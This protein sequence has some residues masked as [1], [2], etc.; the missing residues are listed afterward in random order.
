MSAAT[1]CFHLTIAKLGEDLLDA[2]V[3][4]G[5]TRSADQDFFELEVVATKALLHVHARVRLDLGTLLDQLYK[6]LGL[7]DVLEDERRLL[8]V[9]VDDY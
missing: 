1:F 2:G 4:F 6:G 7:R 5:R 8:V 3:A 9:D